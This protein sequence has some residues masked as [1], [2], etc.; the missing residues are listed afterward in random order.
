MRKT[1]RIIT[2]VLSIILLA[3][4]SFTQDTNT[5]SADDVTLSAMV[6]INK[7]VDEVISREYKCIRFANDIKVGGST[8][9]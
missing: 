5:H 3:G 4:C 9:R 2:S 1:Y 7:N 8:G 6:D